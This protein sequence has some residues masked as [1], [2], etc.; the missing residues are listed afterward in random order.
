MRVPSAEVMVAAADEEVEAA[1]K[2]AEESEF[3]PAEDALVLYG[4]QV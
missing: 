1:A 3:P 4:K 2:Y